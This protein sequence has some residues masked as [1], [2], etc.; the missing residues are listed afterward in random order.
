LGTNFFRETL[1]NRYVTKILTKKR[2]F[3]RFQNLFFCGYEKTLFVYVQNTFTFAINYYYF[4]KIQ[5]DYQLVFFVPQNIP[6]SKTLYFG[7]IN[8]KIERFYYLFS[9]EEI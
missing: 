1:L 5:F 9:I 6:L 8:I 2:E 3:R 4:V 7:A